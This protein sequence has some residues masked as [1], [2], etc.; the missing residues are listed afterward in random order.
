M[1][2]EQFVSTR[3]SVVLAAADRSSP[4]SRDALDTLCRIYW[5]PV[6]AFTRRQGASAHEAEDLTQEFFARLLEKDYLEGVAPEKGRFRSFLLVCLRRF[7]A[8]ERD[9][10]RAAKRGGGRRPLSI[11][12]ADAEGRYRLEPGHQ[13]TPERIFDRRWALALLEQVLNTL[14]RELEASGKGRLFDRLKVYL[15]AQRSAPPYAEAAQELGMTE[16]AVKVAVH[17]LRQRYRRL[18]RAEVARTVGDAD[19][20]DEEIR[21]LLEAVSL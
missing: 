17:R 9:R 14:E 18:L 7:L 13:L 1:P 11:D 6:Y 19:D 16:G 15:A 12:L 4:D 3:W 10:A 21:R 5:Y 8:N 20:V 2:G